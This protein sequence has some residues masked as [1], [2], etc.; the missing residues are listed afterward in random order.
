[1]KNFTYI[2]SLSFF[3]LF[4]FSSFGQWQQ[5]EFM[6]G[7]FMDPMPRSKDYRAD[8]LDYD[9]Q[10]QMLKNAYFNFLSGYTTYNNNSLDFLKFKLK[11][12]QHYQIYT[13]YHIG[14]N[15]KNI[16]TTIEYTKKLSHNLRKY[17][18]GY[19]LFDEPPSEYT[20]RYLIS[21]VRIFDPT[22]LAYVNL[23][24]IYRFNNK[25][26]YEKYLDSLLIPNKVYSSNVASYDFYPFVGHKFKDNYYYNLSVIHQKAGSRPFWFYVRTLPFGPYTAP[27]LYQLSFSTFN[28][29]CYG[30]K[31]YLVFT[32]IPPPLSKTYRYEFGDALIARDGK[33]TDRMD[34]MIT[35]NRFVSDIIG[36]I[37]MRSK[38]IGTYHVSNYPYRQFIPDSEYINVNMPVLSRIGNE[39]MLAGIFKDTIH[40]GNYYILLANKSPYFQNEVFITLKGNY[41]GLATTSQSYLNYQDGDQKFI[42]VP[43]TYDPITNETYLYLDFYPG[44]GRI[45]KIRE[46]TDPF[47]PVN[48]PDHFKFKVFPNPFK[49][50]CNIVYSLPKAVHIRM[51]VYSVDGRLQQT[52]IEPTRF[53][54]GKYYETF[55][56]VFSIPGI[57]FLALFVN[58]K[59]HSKKI[60]FLGH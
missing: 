6:I 11:I 2:F 8:S 39:N 21:R 25:T 33:P 26:G 41:K 54:A 35:I 20:V 56:P 19:F 9:Y 49:N 17:F 32:Y 42:N 27:S 55:R 34:N 45:L 3:L 46:V 13:M 29:I 12:L 43:S 57:Y 1:M 50:S 15:N 16:M 14:F 38:L 52:I 36:P 53:L 4:S 37:V 44:E 28:P 60:V 23:F 31:G 47:Q 5:K 58:N 40:L 30:A 51:A 48:F 22:K 18:L 7:T 24:P 10:I 59:V